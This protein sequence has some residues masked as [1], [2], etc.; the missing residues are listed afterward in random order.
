[1]PA[2]R[3]H[4]PA[5]DESVGADVL[6][7]PVVT[8]AADL[9]ARLERVG[10]GV[11]QAAARALDLGDF[12]AKAGSRLL[13][14]SRGQERFP[15]FLLLGLGEPEKLSAAVIRDAFAGAVG[16]PNVRRLD[17]VAVHCGAGLGDGTDLAANVAAA[18][19]GL[20]AG[21]YQWTAA[22]EERP[23]APG[24]FVFLG[25]GARVRDRI[26]EGIALGGRIGMAVATAKDLANTPANLMSP[27]DLADRA[28]DL[29]KRGGLK[30]R[31]LDEA[32]LDRERCIGIRTVGG[33]SSRPPRLIVLE[34]G[35]NAG[36]RP[37]VLVGK[38]LVFDSGGLNIKPGASMV[39]MKYDK[40]GACAVL[41]A[42][43]AVAGLDLRVPVVAVVPAVENSISG[44]AYRPG[45]VIGSRSGK[46][47][48]VL[49]TDAE[50]RIVLA[51]ALDYA[52][53]KYEPQ[54]VV[55]LAT[56]TGAVYY[57]LGDRACAVLGTDP[58]VIR[59]VQEAG[60]RAGE[61]AWELPLWETYLEDVKTANADVKNTAAFGAGT[62]A[63]ASFLRAF[64]KDVPWAHLDI[65]GVS[66]DRRNPRAGATGFGVRLL[67][68][69]LA[70]WPVPRVRKR[71]GGTA[72]RRTR[73]G[74]RG[75]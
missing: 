55:D 48:E 33:G 58:T 4:V 25:D 5:S 64:V 42:M 23:S 14:H 29:A 67:V 61:R 8:P 74:R 53:T 59:R 39:D 68:E 71:T 20:L 62:I 60:E 17:R 37:V 66:R 50:G 3:S 10:K 44:D 72:K 75:S 26:D 18:V 54:A 24:S 63:G 43:E 36:A 49:N 11:A 21:C 40:C 2:F 65:A 13:V 12:E 9:P 32:A 51:D 73:S 38:G 46:T 70:R 35:V 28:R 41:G 45:D 7:V 52:V 22:T 27:A 47:I 69:L 31:I 15:R 6:V 56:L 57:A 16:E 19:D 34:H 1:M 30:A